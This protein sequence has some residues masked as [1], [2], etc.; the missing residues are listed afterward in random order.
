MYAISKKLFLALVVMMVVLTTGA[1]QGAPAVAAS[2]PRADSLE[3]P[4]FPGLTW[5]APVDS[6]QD[7]RTSITG[8]SIS[9]TGKRYEAQERFLADVPLPQ[10]FVE[11]YSN[12]QLRQAGW[13]SYDAFDA[14]DGV[15]Y[16]FSHESGAYLSVEF[17]K[18]QDDATKACVSVWMSDPGNRN[19][20]AA[21]AAAITSE[22]TP[23][24]TAA[25]FGK[26]SP[27][28][29]TTN[30]NPAS[31]KLSWDAYSPTP[32]KYSYCIQEGSACA[33]NDPDW[34]ST[35]NT[36][37]T[38]SNLGNNKTYYWQV[39]AITCVE[40]TPKTVVYANGGTAWN[41][42]TSTSSEVTILGNAGVA[43][44]V[45][46][47]V[48]GTT[49]KTVTADSIGSYSFKVPYN[50][51]GTVTPSK[52]GYIFTPKSATF[53]NL[54][55][56]QTIQN[57]AA[58]LGY[59]IS[60]NAGLPGVTLSYTDVIAKTVVSDASGNYSIGVPAGWSGTI[61]PSLQPN[62][63]PH[64]WEPNRTELCGHL[65]YLYHFRECGCGW[66]HSKLYRHDG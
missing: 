47:Y 18:C 58:V 32:D 44:A 10:E 33:T 15:H 59:T 62:L 30:L 26:I 7:I 6:S 64:H 31:V 55:A 63:S 51:S 53:T 46:S 50:W 12:G 45:L 40:C 37:V 36:S 11:Y 1:W 23:Q 20:I 17:L 2:Q 60:G 21:S 66:S 3:A 22:Q 9:L 48:I 41:F 56:S 43:S 35:Y 16:V 65:H 14:A 61:T 57:F 42:K 49:N 28:N 25:S 54:T 8:D 4:L 27:T 39:K 38:L 13:E 29:G 52:S 24:A 5:S 34:T 19:A